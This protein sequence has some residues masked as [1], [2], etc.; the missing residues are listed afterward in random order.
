MKAMLPIAH[1]GRLLNRELEARGL[2]A[3]KVALAL[4]RNQRLD[5]RRRRPW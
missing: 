3:S 1:P 2:S 5:T 4:R